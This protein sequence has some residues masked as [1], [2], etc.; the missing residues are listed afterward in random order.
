MATVSQKKFVAYGACCTAT[1]ACAYYHVI[2][3]DGYN[4]ESIKIA[5]S[6]HDAGVDENINTA[7]EAVING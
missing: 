1:K 5:A 7:I 3:S 2:D 6:I 4:Y